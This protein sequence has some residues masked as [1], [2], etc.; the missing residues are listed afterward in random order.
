[1]WGWSLIKLSWNWKLVEDIQLCIKE[2]YFPFYSA[3]S[4][5]KSFLTDWCVSFKKAIANR[6]C[7][8]LLSKDFWAIFHIEFQN[9][10]NCGY[11]NGFM[12]FY[13]EIRRGVP[14]VGHGSRT[15]YGDEL[16]KRVSTKG[17]LRMEI[18]IKS[19]GAT[20]VD[21]KWRW[22]FRDRTSRP[23]VPRWNSEANRT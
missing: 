11:C 6:N 1:M 14:E 16:S 20:D 8:I 5:F 17:D 19:I 18:W 12:K 23:N 9:K 4:Y 2:W 13:F 10:R 22:H 21:A 3:R 15:W 7:K